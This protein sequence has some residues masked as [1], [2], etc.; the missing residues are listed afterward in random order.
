MRWTIEAMD[1]PYR[2]SG[3]VMSPAA[4]SYDLTFRDFDADEWT[5]PRQRVTVSAGRM[6]QLTVTFVKKK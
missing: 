4:G 5:P 2:K 3:E 6:T 1:A